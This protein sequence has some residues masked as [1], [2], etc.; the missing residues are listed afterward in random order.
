MDGETLPAVIRE[1]VHAQCAAARV[2]PERVRRV[3]LAVPGAYNPH[4]DCLHHV[5]VPGLNRPGLV[6]EL[7]RILGVPLTVDNDVNLAAVAERRRGVAGTADSFVLLWFGEGLGLAIDLGGTLLRGANG[8][9]GEI[10]YIAL[11][12]SPGAGRQ[13]D[14]HDLVGGPAVLAL[15]KEHGIEADTPRQAVAQ[16]TPAMLAELA[17]RIAVGLAVVIAVLDP[18][19]VVLAGEVGQAGGPAL[20][21]AVAL[22][23]QLGGAATSQRSSVSGSNGTLIAVTGLT[24]DAVLLGALD[25]GLAEVREDLI[26]NLHKLTR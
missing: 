15:A 25:A 2:P 26:S 7:R 6:G 22:A 5:H 4:T 1:A 20:R 9:A 18:A 24:D 16:A 19:L 3:L 21:D 12:V 17:D 11:G 13:P 10:G 8:G 14:L 23:A